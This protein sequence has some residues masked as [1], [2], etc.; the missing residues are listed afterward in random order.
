MQKL[1]GPISLASL[2]A[3]GLSA[4]ATQPPPPPKPDYVPPKVGLVIIFG[5]MADGKGDPTKPD[6]R[7]EITGNDGDTVLN[8]VT[9]LSKDGVVRQNRTLRSI[10]SYRIFQPGDGIFVDEID[11]DKVRSLWPLEPGKTVTTTE[12][13]LLGLGKTEKAAN[14]RLKPHGTTSHVFK[15]LRF[16]KV[17][18]PAGTFDSVVFQRITTE[19]NQKGDVTIVSDKTYWVARNLNWIVRLD[20]RNTRPGR[21]TRNATLRALKVTQAGAKK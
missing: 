12:R 3:I 10:V 19:R 7:H 2:I 8:T 14:A 5:H 17:T 4:C 11:A 15:V 1:L 13:R 20:T 18:V 9:G 21:P 16:E 6:S